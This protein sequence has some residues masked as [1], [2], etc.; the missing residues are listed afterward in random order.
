MTHGRLPGAATSLRDLEKDLNIICSSSLN[1][2]F[3]HQCL[4]GVG[5]G[6]MAWSGYDIYKALSS[7][8]LL[9]SHQDSCFT[10][11]FMENIVGGL[12]A[13]HATKYMNDDPQYP[14]SIMQD[15]YKSS[16]YFLQTSRMM[17]LFSG[18]FKKIAAACSKAP[19][20][21]HQVCF[22]SMGRDVGG[23]SVGDPVKAIAACGYATGQDRS[24]CLNGTI[25]DTFWDASGADTGLA[26]CRALSSDTDKK[27]CYGLQFGR[28]T[29]VFT[30]PDD[31]K[32]FCSKAE[33]AYQVLC[34]SF[35]PPAGSEPLP[36]R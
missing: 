16:C 32:N 31:I 7:C 22:Q 8:D 5:H 21:Y 20:Q 17:Q 26:F 27:L 19:A 10:G 15:K 25:Q 14:C 23:T 30:S 24:D 33:P 6:L 1:P 18:D 36:V 28:A 13:G 29:Q 4:H 2:F 12:A 35:T 3:S 34:Q 9:S 11:V